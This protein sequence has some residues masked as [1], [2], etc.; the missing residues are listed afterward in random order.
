MFHK[1]HRRTRKKQKT[2]KAKPKYRKSNTLRKY[3]IN[4]IYGGTEPVERKSFLSRIKEKAN[5]ELKK[6]NDSIQ[7]SYKKSQYF[8]AN[9]EEYAEYIKDMQD[10]KIQKAKNLGNATKESVKTTA[11]SAATAVRGLANSTATA[12]RGLAN[13]TAS[14]ISSIGAPI[15]TEEEKEKV[16]TELGNLKESGAITEEEWQHAINKLNEDTSWSFQDTL[17]GLMA[18]I[19]SIVQVVGDFFIKEPTLDDIKSRKTIVKVLRFPK[20]SKA[21]IKQVLGD[22][23]EDIPELDEYMLLYKD[24]FST[25]GEKVE[26]DIN[27]VDNLLANLLNQCK[28]A[29]CK[30]GI[31]KRTPQF[32]K[33]IDITDNTNRK[34]FLS[35]LRDSYK[36][37]QDNN[38][39]YIE[40][41]EE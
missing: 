37:M 41:Y 3:K 23:A 12:V 15:I 4:P 20:S 6:Y 22:N 35:K 27:S 36:E 39:D 25:P 16:I 31:V 38:E 21:Y 2:N 11:Y 1:K 29:Y 34:N 40:D 10:K 14:G 7:E 19:Q 5:E 9:P 33:M 30:D 26:Y 28:G 32:S 24:M 8:K 18:P 17:V 13:S